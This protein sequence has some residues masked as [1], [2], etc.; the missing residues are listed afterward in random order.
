MMAQDPARRYQT[1]AEVAGALSPWATDVANREDRSPTRGA[2][3][4]HWQ[5][6]T[7]HGQRS[8]R[9]VRLALAASIA[10]VLGVLGCLFVPPI[11]DFAQTV[12]RVATNTGVLVIE[13]EDEDLEIGIKRDRTDQGVIARVAKGNKE[14]IELRAGELTI[15]ASLPGGDRLT[16]TELT[17]TRGRRKLLTAKL[18]LAREVLVSEPVERPV[19][20]YED[21]A[22]RT[23]ATH[24]VDVRPRVSG[25]LQEIA[26]REG[27]FVHKGQLLFV[28]DPKP[29]QTL[30]DQARARA[31]RYEVLLKDKVT[32]SEE[33]TSADLNAAKAEIERREWEL[34]VTKIEAPI[35]GQISRYYQT[36]GNLVCEDTMTLTTL[37]SVDPMY[38][39][40]EIDQPTLLRIRRAV[41][42]GKFQRS[43]DGTRLPVFMGLQGEDGFPHQGTVNFVDNR[44]NPTKGSVVVRGVF[45]NPAPPGGH[46]LLS[47]GMSVRLR[48][49]VGP[50]HRALL[51]RVPGP[52]RAHVATP[53][54]YQDYL[55]RYL[56][57][58]QN[59]Q[60]FLY[61]VDDQNKVIRR[62]VKLGQEHD[63]LTVVKEGLKPGDRVI[64]GWT[65]VPR[66][67][68]IVRP[69][70]VSMPG[71]Q[72]EPATPK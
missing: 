71:S 69:K 66:L 39:Y 12:I 47:P 11:R 7:L 50:A 18:L 60:V 44:V 67:G 21:F 2:Q 1:P 55:D 48:L 62:S 31:K 34:A 19:T 70:L 22:G 54:D 24:S 49:P 13:A 68:D 17:L 23:E 64:V 45:P 37:V 41:N 6:P 29:I 63:G 58:D 9:R 27:E 15:A 32:K 4:A 20:D 38:V 28:I 8:R 36:V 59:K 5:P 16:T 30:L 52:P 57:D 3:G 43:R 53:K 40:S 46:R 35:D 51:V 10:V 61:L 72:S 65:E 33:A 42:E 25:Y 14:V 26:F 56:N